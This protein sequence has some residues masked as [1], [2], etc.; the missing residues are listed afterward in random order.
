MHDDEVDEIV[1]HIEML[2][3]IDDDADEAH[4]VVRLRLLLAEVDD[5]EEEAE[6]NTVNEV[7]ELID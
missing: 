7:I 1:Q 3:Y 5:D 6:A 2:L 4:V